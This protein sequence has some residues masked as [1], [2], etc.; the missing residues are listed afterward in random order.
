MLRHVYGALVVALS[1]SMETEADGFIVEFRH[2]LCDWPRGLLCSL[3]GS[4]CSIGAVSISGRPFFHTQ[5]WLPIFPFPKEPVRPELEAQIKIDQWK[6]NPVTQVNEPY[7]S[8]WRRILQSV[9]SGTVVVFMVRIFP[10]FAFSAKTAI[11]PYLIWQF[12]RTPQR[13]PSN[14]KLRYIAWSQTK[15]LRRRR[16][17]CISQEDNDKPKYFF[18]FLSGRSEN[19]WKTIW[20]V[21]SIG[22]QLST[23]YEVVFS[24]FLDCFNFSFQKE[25]TPIIFLFESWIVLTWMT[26]PGFDWQFDVFFCR[27]L[28]CLRPLW[29]RIEFWICFFLSSIRSC[30]E[31]ILWVCIESW[32]SFFSS[33]RSCKE[34]ISR[35]SLRYSVLRRDCLPGHGQRGHLRVLTEHGRGR[36]GGCQWDLFGEIF[37]VPCGFHGGR[38]EFD[39]H[40]HAQRGKEKMDLFAFIYAHNSLL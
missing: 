29:V 33:I 35:F 30:K 37:R 14:T 19:F 20:V 31:T 34:D 7:V 26:S 11:D 4:Q 15:K 8:P 39:R 6:V 13:W 18:C 3:K 36:R 9:I 25:W 22:I 24:I 12:F 16:E 10:A 2:L 1:H 17:L 32:I 21:S 5:K 27:W 40:S 23:Q 28:L 38:A